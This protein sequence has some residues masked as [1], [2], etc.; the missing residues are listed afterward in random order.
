MHEVCAY[1]ITT[2]SR[3]QYK[4]TEWKLHDTWLNSKLLYSTVV[5]YS[6]DQYQ[7]IGLLKISHS[8]KIPGSSVA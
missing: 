1:E 3:I 8:I 2:S 7:I 6:G 5:L 4:K